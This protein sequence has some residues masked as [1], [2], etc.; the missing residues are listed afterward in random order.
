[1]GVLFQAFYQRGNSGVPSPA[2]GDPIDAWWDHLAKQATQLRK[3]GFTAIWLPPVTKGGSG[4]DSVGYDVFDDYDLGSRNQKGT[5]P[6]HYGTREQL[7]RCVAIM[8]AN[9]IDVYVDLVENQRGGGSGP[10]GFTFRYA[11]ADGHIGGGRF[12]KDPSNF[13]PSVPQDPHVF[14]DFS[15]GADLAPI[16]GRPPGYVFNGLIDS[17]DWMTRTLGIQGYRI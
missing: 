5:V 2:D 15:F 16:N 8:R 9:G 3:A 11:D 12:P 1:M 17:A 13:H 10:G 7:A 14:Q 6:T 4:K